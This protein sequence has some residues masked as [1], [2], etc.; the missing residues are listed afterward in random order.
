[1]VPVGAS[2]LQA[3]RGAAHG[4]VERVLSSWKGP[5]TLSP[6]TLNP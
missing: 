2:S 1:M 5:Y 4:D 6:G 3:W